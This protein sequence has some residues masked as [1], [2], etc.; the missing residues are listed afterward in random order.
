M[1]RVEIWEDEKFVNLYNC[2]EN[3][4]K[5]TICNRTLT[6]LQADLIVC[7]RSNR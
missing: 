3:T 2:V 5:L 4:A 6:N 1:T 7:K